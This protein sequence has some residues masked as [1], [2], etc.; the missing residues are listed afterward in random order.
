MLHKSTIKAQVK[1][2]FKDVEIIDVSIKG[3][4]VLV[5]KVKKEMPR[6]TKIGL[7]FGQTDFDKSENGVILDKKIDWV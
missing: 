2:S 1:K 5:I 4:G 6:S 3:F 7:L